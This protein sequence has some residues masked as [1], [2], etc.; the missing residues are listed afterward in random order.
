[1]KVE[2]AGGKNLKMSFFYL[3]VKRSLFVTEFL[4]EFDAP[5]FLHLENRMVSFL[6]LWFAWSSLVKTGPWLYA[7][8]HS[9]DLDSLLLRSDCFLETRTLFG[10]LKLYPVAGVCV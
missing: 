2:A 8:L 6:T 7:S 9:E 3:I 1:M 5:F 4:V 10:S